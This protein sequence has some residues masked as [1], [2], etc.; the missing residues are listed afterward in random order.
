MALPLFPGLMQQTQTKT[1][2][3]QGQGVLLADPVGILQFDLHIS[4]GLIG[5]LTLQRTDLQHIR[6]I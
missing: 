6:V 1:R 4:A 5:R 3:Q 2:S